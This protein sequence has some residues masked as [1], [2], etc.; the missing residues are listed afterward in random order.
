MNQKTQGNG[1]R[2][3][4]PKRRAGFTLVE[5]LVVISIIALLI[6]IL[7]PSLKKARSLS[8][9][10]MCKANLRGMG[11]AFTM[12]GEKYDG[13][14]PPVI[15]TFGSQNRWP[16]PFHQGGIITAQLG[17]FDSSGNEIKRPDKSIFIC[18]ADRSDRIIPDWVNTANPGG[19]PVDRV[20]V[21]GSYAMSE[22]IHR[23]EGKLDLGFFPPPTPIPPFVNNIDN[24]RRASEVFTVM[25]NFKPL[26]KTGDAGWR[27]NRGANYN[28]QTDSFSPTGRG[29]WIGYRTFTGDEYDN[30]KLKIIG[31]RHNGKANALCVDT[32]VE[33][34]RPEKVA[35]NQVSWNRWPKHDETPPGGQ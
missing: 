22:E 28:P 2:E 27:F 29:F 9:D 18:P 15:D 35:Y 13:A 20:E 12:Y 1:W 31:G 30:D 6:S 5:L 14:W 26:E 17:K 33:S 21:G 10:V 3:A 24:C 25:D 8:K 23:K 11:Q 16:V 19:I 32:H 4:A 34:A 7:L